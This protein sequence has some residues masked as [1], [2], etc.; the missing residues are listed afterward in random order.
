FLRRERM[1]FR[2]VQCWGIA[3]VLGWC[4]VVA[5]PAPAADAPRLTGESPRTL[6]RF[7]EAADLEKDRRWADAVELY[8]RLL[9]E[10]G[11]DLVPGDAGARHYL[12]ARVLVHR[13]LAARPELLPPYRTRV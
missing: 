8:L 7:D 10:A 3:A 1:A 13:R 9:D 6:Q 12:P 5:R 4:A 2:R 11:D